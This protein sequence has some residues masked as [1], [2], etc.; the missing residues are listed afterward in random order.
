M[1]DNNDS[2]EN[3]VTTKQ[4]LAT[5]ASNNYKNIC[6]GLNMSRNNTKYMLM[7]WYNKVKQNGYLQNVQE[8]YMPS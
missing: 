7:R 1:Q 2:V 5:A 4:I 8:R 3:S 6:H